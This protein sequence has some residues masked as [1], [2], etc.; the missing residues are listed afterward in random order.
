MVISE[1]KLEVS[2][3]P[4]SLSLAGCLQPSSKEKVDV[5]LQ[6]CS[7]S[8]TF[9]DVDP[10]SNEME[11]KESD[12]QLET[13]LDVVS[14]G[15]GD[16]SLSSSVSVADRS[17]PSALVTDEQA[18]GANVTALSTASD[19]S[20]ADAQSEQPAVIEQDDAVRN[21]SL[22]RSSPDD[23]QHYETEAADHDR[24]T[25]SKDTDIKDI[26]GR[27][28][29]GRLLSDSDA[30]A[31]QSCD[32]VVDDDK[33]LQH[34][35]PQTAD[36]MK[37]ADMHKSEEVVQTRDDGSADVMLS[38]GDGDAATI[39]G[40]FEHVTGSLCHSKGELRSDDEPT[41]DMHESELAV[42]S[43][44]DDDAGVTLP[45]DGDTAAECSELQHLSDH[46]SSGDQALTGTD[47]VAAAS[48]SGGPCSDI[49]SIADMTAVDDD[50]EADEVTLSAEEAAV[51]VLVSDIPQGLEETVEMYLESKKKGGGTIESFKYN[52]RSGSALVVFA[53]NAGD[54]THDSYRLR[55]LC[56]L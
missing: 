45:G 17:R 47:T 13:E 54:F 37:I 6:T 35:L 31:T 20:W 10:L 41:D 50:G 15:L 56:T 42:Q 33:L 5:G 40:E 34:S 2:D 11:K 19:D 16:I 28:T 38:G 18:S 7:G 36:D 12:V 9:S 23:E 53:D 51:T 49:K 48:A 3:E 8:N 43:V 52:E 26:G 24:G 1:P 55:E 25:I 4:E 44:D 21:S 14:E 46:V 39:S 27:D 29:G 32:E 30:A 22:G